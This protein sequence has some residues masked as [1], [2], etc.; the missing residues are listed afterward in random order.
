SPHLAPPRCHRGRGAAVAGIR[1]SR[2]G[3]SHASLRSDAPVARWARG[4][5]RRRVRVEPC[6]RAGDARGGVYAHGVQRR[7]ARVCSD[8]WTLAT[9]EDYR[10][11]GVEG[12]S[13]TI[14]MRVMHR[15]L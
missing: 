5:G 13:R 12:G 2:D 14:G 9:G 3:E 7:L 8:A 6:V 11:K 15:Y 4:P 10:F 1:V